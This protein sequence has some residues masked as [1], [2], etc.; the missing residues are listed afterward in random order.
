MVTRTVKFTVL[1]CGSPGGFSAFSVVPA[2]ALLYSRTF[3]HPKGSL[4]PLAL[5][6]Q[7]LAATGPRSVHVCCASLT[8]SCS[9]CPCA[10]GFSLSV[11]FSRFSWAVAGVGVAWAGSLTQIYHVLLCVSG[12]WGGFHLL[13]IWCPAAGSTCVHACVCV[14]G[15][16]FT[17]G[18]ARGSAAE[19]CANVRVDSWRS[20][21]RG[22]EPAPGWELCPVGPVGAARSHRSCTRT[23]PSTEGPT[24]QFSRGPSCMPP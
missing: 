12:H 3:H 23:P 16:V 22:L 9:P 18:C 5:T 13:V 7:P 24:A 21:Q 20:L 17:S 4:S 14:R 1:K 6:P 15:S 2:P 19:L 10:S 8:E 11:P